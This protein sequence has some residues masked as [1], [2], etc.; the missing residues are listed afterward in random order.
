MHQNKG[1]SRV[2]D[3]VRENALVREIDS[4]PVI[5]SK[6]EQFLSELRS[7]SG[8]SGDLR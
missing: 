3:F 7:S 1:T 8:L 4:T 5:T 6:G 2:I